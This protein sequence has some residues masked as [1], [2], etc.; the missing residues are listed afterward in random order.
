V[1]TRLAVAC[2]S[3]W[4]TDALIADII[5]AASGD[6]S[7]PGP[8]NSAG[9]A[10]RLSQE[11]RLRGNPRARFDRDLLLVSHVG[12][13]LARHV[14]EPLIIP[15][16]IKGWTRVVKDE[17]FLLRAPLRHLPAIENALADVPNGGVRA[18]ARML[19]AVAPSVGTLLGDAWTQ[20][21]RRIGTDVSPFSSDGN[22]K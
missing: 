17:G 20:M 11:S 9:L 7:N 22:Q 10:A 2:R 4:G 5:R 3:A 16:L 21:L 15:Q 13:S 14:L 19:R 6:F 8:D 18:A 12:Y 1:L